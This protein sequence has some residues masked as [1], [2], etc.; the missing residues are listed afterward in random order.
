MPSA[1]IRIEIPEPGFVGKAIQSAQL[2]LE[3]SLTEDSRF[4]EFAA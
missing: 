4:G 2:K 1:Q 3:E